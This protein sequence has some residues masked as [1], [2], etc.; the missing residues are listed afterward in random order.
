MTDQEMHKWLQRLMAGDQAAFE[1]V[2]EHTCDDVY[3]TVSFLIGNKHDVHDVVNEV[4]IEMLKSLPSYD[5]N[6]SFRLWL[7][8]LI[9]RQASNWRR[10][11]WRRFRL[12]DRSRLQIEPEQAQPDESVLQEE[13]KQELTAL[14]NKLSYKLRVVI[15]LRYYH[16]YSL[17]EIASL[18]DIPVGTV[19]SR[20]HLALKELRKCY[21]TLTDR[22]VEAPHVY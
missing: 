12:F 17:E 13:A 15:I 8:G 7:H 16:D 5:P 10:K 22:K 11:I 14:I 21:F 19:K 3:R 18:L 4:Y 9:V 20:H 6:R 1:T 2:Y